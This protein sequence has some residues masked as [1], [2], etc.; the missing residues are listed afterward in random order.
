[1]T[2][3]HWLAVQST[4]ISVETDGLSRLCPVLLIRTL[5]SLIGRVITQSSR[6]YTH[7]TC[8]TAWLKRRGLSCGYVD[9]ISQI[10]KDADDG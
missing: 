4:R 9:A 8:P 5:S 6:V 1:M 7:R 10:W 2:D 3:R